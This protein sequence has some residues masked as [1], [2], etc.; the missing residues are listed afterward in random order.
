M[1]DIVHL[2]TGPRAE[3][4]QFLQDLMPA[5]VHAA[6]ADVG[7]AGVQAFFRGYKDSQES[8][9]QAA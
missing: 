8:M 6:A 2:P 7:L 5:C 9:K 3:D 4:V 1:S